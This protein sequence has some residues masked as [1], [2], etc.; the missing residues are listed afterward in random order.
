MWRMN[1]IF[2]QMEIEAYWKYFKNSKKQNVQ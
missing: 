1:N 2:T